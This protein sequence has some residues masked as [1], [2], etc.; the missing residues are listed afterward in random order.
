MYTVYYIDTC[1]GQTV[2]PTKQYLRIWATWPPQ[3]VTSQSKVAMENPRGLVMEGMFNCHVWMQNH[4]QNDKVLD[5]TKRAPEGK[6]MK[7][8]YGNKFGYE[9]TH[10]KLIN[11]IYHHLSYMLHSLMFKHCQLLNVLFPSRNQIWLAGRSHIQ[12]DD[13]PIQTF[14]FIRGLLLP[15]FYCL[16]VLTLQ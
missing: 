16:K 11:Q 13:S 4:H 7:I 8:G 3:N 6:L 12:F 5:P 14:M 15:C 2:F 10:R 9:W 1:W